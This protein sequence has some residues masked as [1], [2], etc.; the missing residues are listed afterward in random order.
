MNYFAVR[1]AF[2]NDII[3]KY[4]KQYKIDLKE[5][6]PN[7][8]YILKYKYIC[9]T[10]SFFSYLI[11]K[12]NITPNFITLFNLFFG[13]VAFIIFVADIHQFKILGLIIKIWSTFRRNMWARLLFFYFPFINFS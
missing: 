12:T 11:L 7:P 2:F 9:E 3:K 5:W 4:R 1:K 6:L 8:Y 13:V 10:S